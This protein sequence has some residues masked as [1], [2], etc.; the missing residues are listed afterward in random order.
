MAQ[1]AL[2]LKKSFNSPDIDFRTLKRIEREEKEE[3]YLNSYEYMASLGSLD[4]IF[5]SNYF[6]DNFLMRYT[7][8]I[9]LFAKEVCNT[10]L[11]WQQVDICDNHNPYGGR[12]AVPSGHGCGK[13][14]LIGILAL[15]H[16]LTA[17]KSITRIQAPKLEQVTKLSFG[18]VINSIDNMRLDVNIGGAIVPN[19]GLSWQTFFR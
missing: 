10:D 14:K 13:T 3:N 1:Y 4:E 2:D 9:P 7:D 16:M 15:H 5:D 11:T 18:E 12:L 8:N 19:H 6:I 17:R